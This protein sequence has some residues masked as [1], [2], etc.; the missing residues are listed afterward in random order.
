MNRDTIL[1]VDDMKT[2]RMVLKQLFEKEY[3]LLEAENGETAIEL[4]ERHCR[5]IA[6]MLLDVMMPGKNGHQVLE[7]MKDNGLL[8][9]VP[10]IVITA[11]QSLEAKIRAFELGASDIITKP[12]ESYVVKRRVKNIIELYQHRHN[13][14]ELVL[15]QASELRESN[16]VMI[17]ALSSAI[18]HRS[19]ESGQHIRRIRI[20]TK[21]LL[22]EM[23]KDYP[24]YR[25]D[26]SAI[27]VIASASMLHDIGKISIPDS[28]LNKPAKLTPEEFEV[29]KTHT[30]KG[31][32]ILDNLKGMS[33][34]AYIR[35][36]YEIC[37]YH[38]ERW[39]GN[40][41]PEGLV[42][43]EIPVWAQVTGLADAYDA[44]TSDRVYKKAISHEKAVEMI[45][46][47]QC[48]VFSPKLLNCF[49]RVKEKMAAVE[50]KYTDGQKVISGPFDKND[51]E[52]AGASPRRY[53]GETSSYREEI[54]T[55]AMLIRYG[56][57]SGIRT[58]RNDERFTIVYMEHGFLGYTEK[59]IKESFHNEYINLIHPDDRDYVKEQLQAQLKTGINY[60]LEY[61]LINSEGKSTWMLSK[62]HLATDED[63]SELLSGFLVNIDRSK[64][65]EQQLQ[66]SLERYRIVMEQTKDIVFEWD[67]ETDHVEYSAQA[68][69]KFGYELISENIS[70]RLSSISHI[71]PDDV[72]PFMELIRSMKNRRRYAEMELR[73][74]DAAGNYK[75]FRIRGT[76]QSDPEGKPC[77]VIG[78]MIDINNEKEKTRQLKERAELDSLT[79]LYNKESG[80]RLMEKELELSSE[81]LSCAVFVV[82]LDNFKQIN[83]RYGHMFGDAVLR[84]IAELFTQF[85]RREDIISRIG[86][87]E[88]LILLPGVD[89]SE[90]AKAIADRVLSQLDKAFETLLSGCHV[91]CSI[92]IAIAPKDGKEYNLLFQ[93]ADKAMYQA[94]ESGKGRSCVYQNELDREEENARSREVYVRE[95]RQKRASRKGKALPLSELVPVAFRILSSSGNITQALSAVMGEVQRTIRINRTYIFEHSDEDPYYYK[96]VE[97]CSRT[98]LPMD[99]AGS[100]LSKETIKGE[101]EKQ[102]QDQDVVYWMDLSQM[103]PEFAAA[104]RE[105]GVK[106][107]FQC[108]I[109]DNGR[110]K[111]WIGFES[112]IEEHPWN[113]EQVDTL[114]VLAEML[115]FFLQ[116][117]RNQEKYAELIKKMQHMLDSQNEW[118]YVIEDGTFKLL[119]V[120]RRIQNSNPNAREGMICYNAFWNRIAPCEECPIKNSPKEF[121]GLQRVYDTMRNV[122]IDLKIRRVTWGESDAYLIVCHK[123]PQKKGKTV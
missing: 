100:G 46:D 56:I 60:E 17:E 61:R 62:G 59:Q 55:Q 97:W 58:L 78:I 20:L 84:K 16:D 45:L 50:R 91:S 38:H 74:A 28:I 9:E 111:G 35:Y 88:F 75:W 1:I 4:L 65:I 34:K 86:G 52:F 95:A 101:Y 36:A 68:K 8:S 71:H 37:K 98:T 54:K 104:F 115:S 13:L 41:Y 99:E 44:L 85:F 116:S 70:K 108:A 102:F 14:E 31:C 39:D 47:G 94:K 69:E 73:I 67:L 18:E 105:R 3:H 119:H 123:V 112:C 12:F 57:M 66:M 63:G 106:A 49:E 22:K 90:Q 96:T 113:K 83:D 80:R 51:E 121:S 6:I 48:G 53:E 122:W 64:R 43:D 109:R 93:K 21:I 5:K 87:D 26:D 27:N 19:F 79:K 82:D 32:E 76:L 24:E 2:N 15:E 81:D 7:E 11:D 40:G 77:K 72:G 30:E 29:M 25:L 110:L 89:G 107:V 118:S 33:N 42:G 92:G 23:K 117:K 103:S 120:S 114:S 10:V